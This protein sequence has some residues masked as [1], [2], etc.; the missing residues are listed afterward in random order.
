MR[1]ETEPRG[2]MEPYIALVVTIGTGIGLALVILAVGVVAAW[3]NPDA[4]SGASAD[5]A[6]L[7]NGEVDHAVMDFGEPAEPAAADRVIEMEMLDSLAFDPSSVEVSQGETVTFRVTNTGKLVH[8]F[9]LG[10]EATQEA[11]AAEMADMGPM[12]EMG[13]GGDLNAM[14]LDPGETKEL[15][16]KFTEP[17]ELLIGC[18]IPGHFEAGMVSEV[19]VT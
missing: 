4:S 14:T 13:G 11:H 19:T 3:N 10:N 2:G 15:A 12:G 8:D 9:T 17:G 6:A 5:E 16:W 18:Q 7:A 1:D